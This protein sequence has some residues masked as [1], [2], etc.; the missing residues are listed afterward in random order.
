H[1]RRYIA[2]V[3]MSRSLP[4]PITML[5]GNYN[6][7]YESFLLRADGALIGFGAIMT[8]EQVQLIQ[9][10]KSQKYEA[11]GALGRRVQ[12]LADVVF[13]PPVANYRARLKEGLVMLGVMEHSCVREPVL[14]ISDDE[15][16]RLR[17]AL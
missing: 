5:T 9:L 4:R 6:S 1:A 11:A 3:A 7:L 10:A 17:T 12:A 15:R 2:T 8:R 14:S 16:R 13:A